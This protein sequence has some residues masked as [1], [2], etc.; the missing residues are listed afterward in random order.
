[1]G[2]DVAENLR[3]VLGNLPD[4]VQLVAVSK[5]HSEEYIKAAY[6]AGQR[7]F[8]ESHEQELEQKR[9]VLPQDLSLIHISEPT[10]P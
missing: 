3:E 4:G 9:Q 1:M 6:A 8:G 10:R 5:F 7:V 2:T